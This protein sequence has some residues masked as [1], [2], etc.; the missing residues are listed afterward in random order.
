[1]TA[2]T[3]RCQL[4]ILPIGVETRVPLAILNFTD[5]CLDVVQ[6]QVANLL[7]Q[8]VEI[9]ACCSELCVLVI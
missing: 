2:V 9:H 7:L 5:T 3:T 6:R 4:C 1:M 8:A